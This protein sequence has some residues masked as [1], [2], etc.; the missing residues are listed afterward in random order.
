MGRP[1]NFFLHILHFSF[2]ARAGFFFREKKKESGF[3]GIRERERIEC[4]K[5]DC[6]GN[7]DVENT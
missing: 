6:K 1:C 5:E 4:G 2:P 7:L 3:W